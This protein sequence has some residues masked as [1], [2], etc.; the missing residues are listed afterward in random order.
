MAQM[1]AVP[2]WARCRK[3]GAGVEGDFCC[4]FWALHLGR[5]HS[6]L[7]GRHLTSEG[8]MM[9]KGAISIGRGL[10]PPR[11]PWIRACNMIYFSP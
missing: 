10:R 2:H 4:L 5:H 3:A 6:K 1:G 9:P 7:K 11:P 8:G